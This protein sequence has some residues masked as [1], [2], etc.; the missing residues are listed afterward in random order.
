MNLKLI[1]RYLASRIGSKIVIIY[2]GSRNK[3]ERYDGIL[4]KIYY[5]VGWLRNVE[6]IKIANTLFNVKLL[7]S[8]AIGIMQAKSARSIG[9]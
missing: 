3:K 8:V 1:K 6:S 5:K 2:Y 9:I 4:L 7:N